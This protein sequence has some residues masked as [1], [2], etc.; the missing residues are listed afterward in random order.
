MKQITALKSMLIMLF[1]FCSFSV[2]GQTLEGKVID[3]NGD[4]LPYANVIE[5][6]TTNG[7]VTDNNGNFSINPSQLPAQLEFSLL[8]FSNVTKEALSSNTSMT[9]TLV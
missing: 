5:K 9:V 7:T 4:P 6:G 1:C 2:M 3:E 8:G